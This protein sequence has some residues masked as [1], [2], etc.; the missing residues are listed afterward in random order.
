MFNIYNLILLQLFSQ[1]QYQKPGS[2]IKMLEEMMFGAEGVA[3]KGTSLK[4]HV[5]R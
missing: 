5:I 3:Y 1:Y 2:D 4:V